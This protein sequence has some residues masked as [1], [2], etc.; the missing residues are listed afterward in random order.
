[1]G[2]RRRLLALQIGSVLALVTLPV[3]FA[4]AQ[5]EAE[6]QS[7]VR[8]APGT[9]PGFW[10]IAAELAD[11]KDFSFSYAQP[12]FYALL[13]YVKRNGLDTT[14]PPAEGV[15]W[16]DLLERPADFRGALLRIHGAVVGNRRWKHNS[17][18]YEDIG[19]VSEVLLTRAGEPI[20]CKLILTGDASDVPL[21][22]VIDVDAYFVTIQHYY[23]ESNRQRQAAVFIGVGPTTVATTAVEPERSFDWTGPIVATTLGFLIAYLILRR[24]VRNRGPAESLR[25]SRPAPMHLADDLAEWARTNQGGGPSEDGRSSTSA[26]EHERQRR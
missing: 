26:D 7:A 23:S 25:A 2:N 1:M 12:G 6:S 4:I 20:I 10:D 3:P 8:L 18:E 5:P 19:Y 24:A 22:A 9:E 13:R 11:I 16:K 15:D 21:G 14:T 17:A